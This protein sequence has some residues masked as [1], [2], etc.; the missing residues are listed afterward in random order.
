[1]LAVANDLELENLKPTKENQR[2]TGTNGCHSR[3][4]RTDFPTP[5]LAQTAV[6]ADDGGG[7]DGA[8]N[9][10]AYA[11]ADTSVECFEC[12][13]SVLE[14]PVELSSMHLTFSAECSTL[15]AERRET[16]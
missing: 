12:L 6:A 2:S 3:S 7:D 10:D 15:V 1:M 16:H 9:G 13:K 11:T 8:S 14:P 5:F 4:C